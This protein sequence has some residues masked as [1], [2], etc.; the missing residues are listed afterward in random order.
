MRFVD[1]QSARLVLRRFTDLDLARFQAYRNDWEV[2][3]YQS[4]ETFTQAEALQFIGEQKRLEPL[5]PGRWFQIA[6]ALRE[7]GLLVGDCAVKIMEEDARLAEIGFTF[8]REHQRKG[9]ATEAVRR[10]LDF[11]F[12][13]AGLHRVVAITDCENK[14]AIA[15]L[16]RT[17][18][19]RE[20]HFRQNVWFKGKW[21]DEYLYAILESEWLQKQDA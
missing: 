21:G 16:E 7:S 6:V 9:Y 4:W 18:F 15:L 20:G 1:L 5:L 13:E 10:L 17:S 11:L 12:K 2:S 3:R 14:A 8:A 19:R